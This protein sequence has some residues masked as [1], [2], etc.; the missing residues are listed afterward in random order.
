MGIGLEHQPPHPGAEFGTKDPFARIGEQ[1]LL[2]L[3]ADMPH[4]YVTEARTGRVEPR[5]SPL[6]ALYTRKQ[7][8]PVIGGLGHRLINWCCERQ[9]PLYPA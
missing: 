2:D 4:R 3:L 7:T 1:H 9:C 8:S 5:P 6:P